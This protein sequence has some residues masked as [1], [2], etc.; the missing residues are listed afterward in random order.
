MQHL[1]RLTVRKLCIM[2]LL[3]FLYAYKIMLFTLLFM[4]LVFGY[5]SFC[6][7]VRYITLGVAPYWHQFSGPL[8][9]NHTGMF[10]ALHPYLYACIGPL[11]SR[12][13]W[14][15]YNHMHHWR[16]WQCLTVS[17]QNIIIS[18]F[19]STWTLLILASLALLPVIVCI[20]IYTGIDYGIIIAGYFH[21]I[22]LAGIIAVISNTML[23]VKNF[24]LN[25]LLASI[26]LFILIFVNFL[27]F[28]TSCIGLVDLSVVS[29][30]MM[31]MLGF[32]LLQ[33]YLLCNKNN[34]LWRLAA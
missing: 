26:S 7:D 17:A 16:F 25:W 15:D 19:L 33:A 13:V 30:L 1:S 8:H 20:Q 12:A 32:L 18:K 23:L 28:D 6:L 5:L 11:I 9:D 29:F 3:S 10:F 14:Y 21:S 24:A 22:C 31:N 2:D 4:V 27:H 34:Q